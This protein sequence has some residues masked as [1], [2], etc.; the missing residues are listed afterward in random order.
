MRRTR[1]GQSF[2]RYPLRNTRE[3]EL[4]ALPVSIQKRPPTPFCPLLFFFIFIF[5]F[6]HIIIIIIIAI[7]RSTGFVGVCFTILL[8]IRRNNGFIT[9]DSSI[10]IFFLRF[11]IYRRRYR[12]QCERG[13]PRTYAPHIYIYICIYRSTARGAKI[14]APRGISRAFLA[15]LIYRADR[16][17]DQRG[18]FIELIFSVYI[19]YVRVCL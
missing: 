13:H 17:P 9:D 2:S 15:P 10:Y 12:R 16:R 6:H 19:H 8:Y 1:L 5:F 3:G 14:T 7:I 4:G 18:E 11:D